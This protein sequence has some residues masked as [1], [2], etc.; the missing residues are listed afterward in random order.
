[1]KFSSRLGI[2]SGLTLI[3][4]GML[5]MRL[6]FIQVAEGAAAAQQTESQ[7]WVYIGTEAPR[8]DIRDRDGTLLATSR[9]VPAVVVDRHLVSSDQRDLLIQRLSSLLSIPAA[10]I[11]RLYDDAGVNG[12]FAVATV[13]TVQAY[14]I[15][16]NLRDFPGVQIEKVPERVYLVGSSMSH[17]LGYL[18]LPSEDDLDARPEL[19]PNVRIGR[20]GVEAAYDSFLI[21]RQGEIAFQVRAGEVI[22]QRP[23]VPA[24]PGDT[25]YLTL[26]L[27]LQEIVREAL[28]AGIDLSNEWKA[29]QRSRGNEE[30]AKNET[31]RAAAVVLDART[32]AVM[33]MSSLPGYDPSLFVKGLDE[34]TFADLRD[35]EALFN[36]AVSG[37]YPPASTFKAFTYMAAM[38]NDVPLPRNVEGVDAGSGVVHCDGRLELPTLADGSPQVFRDWYTG[39][40]GWL[41]IHAAF[42]QSCNIYFWSIALGIWENWRRT[43]QE[44]VIQDMARA[45]GYGTATGIDIGGEVENLGVVPDRELFLEYQEQQRE[46][47]TIRRLHPDRMDLADPWFGGDLM[48]LAIGQGEILA[49]PLQVAVSY[50]ALANG[51]RV[52]QPYVVE[53]VRSIDGEL[54]DDRAPVVASEVPLDQDNV[55]S[56]L[57][58]MNRVVTGGTASTAFAGFGDSLSLVGGKTGTGQSLIAKDNHAWFVGVAPLNEPR[59]VV[60]VLIDEGGSGGAVAAPVARRIM[61]YLMGEELDPITLG[62]SAQ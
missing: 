2:L 25:V 19:N 60:V 32:G 12:R 24:L 13:D 57:T 49:T 40:K 41:N 62:A 59:Y 61:Q 33:A 22:E 29:E 28:V 4:F 52:L 8:G 35:T 30:A 48:N 43:P 6:W 42:E 39:D 34:A 18:G 44:T 17:V 54:V 15:S 5:G 23:E 7:S 16:E 10:D 3:L 26:D 56:F 36:R 14:Q 21:G 45:V 55:E 37:L 47:P 50:A 9:F 38:E 27:D 1:V 11:A 31:K 53:Q 46:D 58:D 20:T 51:G